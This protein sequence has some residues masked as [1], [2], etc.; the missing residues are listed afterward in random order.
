M[1]RKLSAKRGHSKVASA[2]FG[3]E[4]GMARGSHKP[5]SMTPSLSIQSGLLVSAVVAIVGCGTSNT[6]TVGGLGNGGYDASYD[7][8]SGNSSG[9]IPNNSNYNSSSSGGSS[10]GSN[11]SSNGG[12]TACP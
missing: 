5:G 10:S 7:S 8:T 4:H 11:G 9:N 2:R 12:G 3:S 6:S 1:V